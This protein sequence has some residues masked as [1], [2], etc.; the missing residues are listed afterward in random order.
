M[1]ETAKVHMTRV[2]FPDGSFFW[3]GEC[4]GCDWIFEK[5]YNADLREFAATHLMVFH[6]GGIITHPRFEIEVKPK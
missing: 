3:R 6:N 2:S 4:N 1:T 5:P